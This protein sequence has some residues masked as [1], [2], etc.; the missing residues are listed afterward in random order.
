MTSVLRRVSDWIVQ[1]LLPA[2]LFACTLAP[3]TPRDLDDLVAPV[4]ISEL[5]DEGDAARR[6]SIRLII[7]GLDADEQGYPERARGDYERALQV[8]ATNPYVYLSLARHH[9]DGVDPLLALPLLDRADA[10][11]DLQGE[12]SPRVAAHLLGLRGQIYYASGRV[13]EGIDYLERA[14]ALAPYVW[15]DGELAPSELR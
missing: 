8:D 3:G 2:L 14:R 11:F 13:S 7:E 9:A 1:P 5:A 12:E 15:S 6:A 4:R 10:L